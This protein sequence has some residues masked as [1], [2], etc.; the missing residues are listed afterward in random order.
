M[1]FLAGLDLAIAADGF[2]FAAK[3]LQGGAA[4]VVETPCQ[5]AFEPVVERRVGADRQLAYQ[6]IGMQ[7]RQALAAPLDVP[8]F[9]DGRAV[10]AE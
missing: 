1:A 8:V 3:L 7:L 2:L 5:F 6:R 10:A 4:G 9:E